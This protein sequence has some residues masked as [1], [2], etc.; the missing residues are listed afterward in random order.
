MKKIFIF[1]ILI[2]FLVFGCIGSKKK[3]NSKNQKEAKVITVKKTTITPKDSISKNIENMGYSIGKVIDKTK[4]SGCTFV[5]LVND[6][7]ILEPVNLENKFKKDGLK[8]AFKS[9][10]SRAMSTCMIGQTIIVSDVK[11]L[12]EE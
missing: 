12:K 5:I 10:K 9:R 11:S 3:K 7:T 2:V 1:N 6:S 8:I 4:T